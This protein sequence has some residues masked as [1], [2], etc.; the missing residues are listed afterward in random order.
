MRFCSCK[1]LRAGSASPRISRARIL[2]GC[3]LNVFEGGETK[4]PRFLCDAWIRMGLRL[5]AR[6]V[7]ACY[8]PDAS[9]SKL[10]CV[11]AN[12]SLIHGEC[13]GK[14]SSLGMLGCEPRM[15]FMG[16]VETEGPSRQ[17]NQHQ[18]LR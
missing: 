1:M 2:G 5:P 17:Y 9:C 13:D 3:T 14:E 4:I 6:T 15:K 11:C 18:Q 7:V 16:T 12:E 8:I 10:K